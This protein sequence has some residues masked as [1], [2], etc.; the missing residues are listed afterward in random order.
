MGK[1]C[2]CGRETE[3][4]YVYYR[5][6]PAQDT[7]KTRPDDPRGVMS[8]MRRLSPEYERIEEQS[9]CC[10]RRCVWL[11]GALA[12]TAAGAALIALYFFIKSAQTSL[13]IL[14][15]GLGGASLA[16]GIYHIVSFILDR[17]DGAESRAAFIID[18][19]H[20][21]MNGA[22]QEYFTPAQAAALKVKDGGE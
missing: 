11:P 16:F 18:L 17:K 14:L 3:R 1:C 9:A 13:A 19:L 2:K 22:P 20:P 21:R 4:S 6:I 8:T 10:C 15:L 5:A 12:F 7:G